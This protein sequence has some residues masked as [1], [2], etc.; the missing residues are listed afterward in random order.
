MIQ[1]G[2]GPPKMMSPQEIVQTLQ[3]QH[4]IINELTQRLR[5]AKSEIEMYKSML[6][7]YD[8][9]SRKIKQDDNILFQVKEDS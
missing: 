3:K 1:Q 2:N 5:F 6:S 9:E 7:N 4:T 8:E